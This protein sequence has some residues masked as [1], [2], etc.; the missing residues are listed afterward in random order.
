MYPDTTLPKLL[1]RNYEKWGDQ[2]VAMRHKDLGIW[3]SYS[4][5]DVYWKVRHFALGLHEL[6]IG[7]ADKVCIIGDNEPEWYLSEW[8]IQAVGGIAVGIFTDCVVEEVLHIVENSESAIVIAKD[9][10]QVDKILALKDDVDNLIKVIYWDDKGMYGYIDPLIA[11]WEDTVQS[12]KKRDDKDPALFDQLLDAGKKDDVAILSYTSGTTSLPKGAMVTHQNL[13][14]TVSQ[15]LK[16]CPWKE[17]DEYLSYISPAW[18]TEQMLGLC[19]TLLAGIPVDLPESPETVSN[20]VREIGPACLIYTSRLWE[21]LCG[22]TQAKLLD[23]NF[24][25]KYLYNLL[26]PVGYR[27]ADAELEN[28]NLPLFWRLLVKF[29]DIVMFRC[30]R[31]RIGLAK[32]RSPFTGGALLGSDL[33]RWYRA[34]GIPLKQIYGSSEAGLCAC[35]YEGDINVESIGKA[36]PGM[37]VKVDE[38]GE[39]YWRGVGIFKGYYKNPVATEEALTDGWWRSGDALLTDDQGHIFFLDRI[40]ECG[41]ALDSSNHK[42]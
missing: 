6:G 22:E 8:A 12:G 37:E 27:R 1:K 40:K 42:M 20:D 13:I 29:A 32:T 28:R 35:H 19:G 4:Y 18:I 25:E 41:Y 34:I 17:G 11:S 33:F 16:V 30:I 5:T 39:A 31:D 14:G 9:Q 15:F 3:V 36:L 7:K 10:E 2:R 21:S 38:T 23:A 26:L 24:F